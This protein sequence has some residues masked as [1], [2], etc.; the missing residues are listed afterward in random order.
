MI[1]HSC[2]PFGHG[3]HG[4]FVSKV[5]ISCH[6]DLVFDRCCRFQVVPDG[7]AAKTGKIRIGD[8]ILSVNGGDISNAAHQDAVDT[9]I[10]SNTKVVLTIRHEQLPSGW[11]VLFV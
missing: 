2:H 7:L 11:K 1:D 10:R 8:R 3:E 9:L 6:F 4:I 5:K